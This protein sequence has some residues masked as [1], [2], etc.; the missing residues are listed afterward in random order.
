METLT[1][2]DSST[3]DFVDPPGSSTKINPPY[4]ALSYTWGPNLRQNF[5]I[6]HRNLE[7]RRQHL[8]RDPVLAGFLDKARKSHIRHV[9]TDCFVDYDDFTIR[10]EAVNNR[11]RWVKGAVMCFVYLHD[12]PPANEPSQRFSESG[13]KNCSWFQN[14][15]T[16]P[17]LVGPEVVIF[18]DRDWKPR[19]KKSDVELL[20]LVSKITDIHRDVLADSSLVSK[21]SV[22]TK[23]AWAAN[24][25]P[26]R[27]EDAAYSIMGLIGVTMPLLYGEG[28]SAFLRLQREILKQ[29]TDMS[30]LAWVASPG[31]T[32]RHR[33]S[34]ALSPAEFAHFLLFRELL[35]LEPMSFDGIMFTSNRGISIIDGYCTVFKSDLVLTLGSGGRD[36]PRFGIILRE[37]RGAFVR[38]APST[39]IALGCP[40]RAL[41]HGGCSSS[42]TLPYIDFQ[43]KQSHEGA[44]S[45]SLFR[46]T[47]TLQDVLAQDSLESI[48]TPFWPRS[49]A[50]ASIHPEHGPWSSSGVRARYVASGV[51]PA[52]PRVSHAK[53]SRRTARS[54]RN[55]DRSDGTSSRHCQLQEFLLQDLSPS[56]SSDKPST[57][58]TFETTASRLEG[59]A[60]PR[61]LDKQSDLSR[62]LEDLV[63][64]GKTTF[65]QWL[66]LLKDTVSDSRGTSF[67]VLLDRLDDFDATDKE[68]GKRRQASSSLDLFRGILVRD[69]H[70]RHFL[71]LEPS[72]KCPLWCTDPVQYRSCVTTR[73]FRR[74]E[75]VLLHLA[76]DHHSPQ[77]C[78]KCSAVFESQAS[79]EHHVIQGLCRT[80]APKPTEGLSKDILKLVDRFTNLSLGL[81]DTDRWYAMF[82]IL[83]PS[84]PVPES[85]FVDGLVG[86][87]VEL[88][89][90]FWKEQGKELVSGFLGKHG[91]LEWTVPNE[92]R[93]LLA[94][95]DTV[96]VKLL[97]SLVETVQDTQ[98]SKQPTARYPFRFQQGQSQVPLSSLHVPF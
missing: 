12:L 41:R 24:R 58:W 32:M 11:Y 34:L 42:A 68:C 88:A 53:I 91:M 38:T 67:V 84:H 77:T 86:E 7:S 17:D 30:V 54:R 43:C 2:I 59:E 36:T 47:L 52:K 73:R 98:R 90:Y 89:R 69:A 33:G 80:T 27:P 57:G 81:L 48:G 14:P 55:V 3:L 71:R 45:L 76:V 64:V 9:W 19:G 66:T 83:F 40:Y 79:W 74:F 70:S 50:W 51:D 62:F 49:W 94:L 95:H 97:D 92:E 37:S 5:E 82:R 96:L 44:S 20:D 28:E 87:T 60:Q 85:A 1:L 29:S 22:G 18:F 31:S 23:I 93:D 10:D 61:I 65:V 63:Q 13:W 46:T 25:K 8:R 39:L 75:N 21:V 6:L 15:W 35:W 72:F 56:L 4:L 26:A 16:L 78:P